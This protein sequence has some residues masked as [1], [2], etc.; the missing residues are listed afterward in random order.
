[1]RHSLKQ[2]LEKISKNHKQKANIHHN[3]QNPDTYRLE[4]LIKVYCRLSI[5]AND[6]NFSLQFEELRGSKPHWPHQSAR[7]WPAREERMIPT[8]RP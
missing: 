1:M 8:M 5:T 2:S 3:I 7:D 6:T 4:N